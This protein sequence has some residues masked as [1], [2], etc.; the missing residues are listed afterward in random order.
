MYDSLSLSI[1]LSVSHFGFHP[2]KI[3]F[4][5]MF[6]LI[7][8][9]LIEML[10]NL[11]KILTNYCLSSRSY[12]IDLQRTIFE[13][14]YWNVLAEIKDFR[15]FWNQSSIYSI[16]LQ[17]VSFLYYYLIQFRLLFLFQNKRLFINRIFL[18]TF[19]DLKTLHEELNH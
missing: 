10:K 14:G 17:C 3:S 12:L 5:K 13:N 7:K 4:W 8:Q 15:F 18:N 11:I 1:F 16:Q 6:N 2:T 9:F 19:Q